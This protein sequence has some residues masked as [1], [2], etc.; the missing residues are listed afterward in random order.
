MAWQ[1]SQLQMD[2]QQK[3]ALVTLQEIGTAQN[4]NGYRSATVTFQEPENSNQPQSVT[5]EFLKARAKQILLDA[6]SSI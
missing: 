3:R 5:E 6:A 4:P 2:Y 1:I